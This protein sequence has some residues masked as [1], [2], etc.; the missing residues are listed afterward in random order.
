MASRAGV[1]TGEVGTYLI[2]DLTELLYAVL[3]PIEMLD[4]A[5]ESRGGGL[6]RQCHIM[7]V[8][9]FLLVFSIYK[10]WIFR[11]IKT[12]RVVEEVGHSLVME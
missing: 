6:G 7:G 8:V 9:L 3:P 1:N 10:R 12:R 2:V 11:V 4:L 5:I